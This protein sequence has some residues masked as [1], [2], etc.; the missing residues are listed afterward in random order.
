MK[1]YLAA[2][3]VALVVFIWWLSSVCLLFYILLSIA[4]VF[5]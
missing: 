5:I 2:L 4:K 3:F 1:D